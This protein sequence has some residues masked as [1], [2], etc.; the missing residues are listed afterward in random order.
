MFEELG[1]KAAAFDLCGYLISMLDFLAKQDNSV[2]SCL[3]LFQHI[4]LL[5]IRHIFNIFY[6]ECHNALLE[7]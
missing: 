3:A 7:G 5:Y 6:R 1:R 4:R 2:S